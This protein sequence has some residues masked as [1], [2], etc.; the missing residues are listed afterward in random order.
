MIK[1]MIVV[2]DACKKEAFSDGP[3]MPDGWR[4]VRWVEGLVSPPGR[5]MLPSGRYHVCSPACLTQLFPN[6]AT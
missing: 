2:C 3:K 1:R 5:E 6:E 4:S